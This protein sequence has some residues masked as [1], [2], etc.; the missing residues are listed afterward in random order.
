MSPVR[1][2]PRAERTRARRRTAEPAAEAPLKTI[3]DP[4]CLVFAVPDLADGTLSSHDRDML[5]AARLLA[6]AQSGAVVVVAI[7]GEDDFAAAGADRLIEVRGDAFTGYCP[8]AR[9]T[10]VIAAMARFSPRHVLFPDTPTDGGHVGRLVAA[11]LGERAAGNVQRIDGSDI[12]RR[13]GDGSLDYVRAAPRFLLV[14]PEAAAPVSGA[15]F[16]ARVIAETSAEGDQ[17]LHDGGLQPIDPHGVPLAEADFIVAGGSGVS[18]W[19]AFHRVAAALGATEGA[20]RVACD[21]GA[22]A[23]DRQVGASGTLVDPRCYLAFGI[24]GA[25]QHLQG[26]QRCPRVVGGNTDRHAAMVKRADLAVIADAQDVMV[27]LADL[28]EGKPH[29]D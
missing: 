7:A 1:R 8:E 6:D 23:R 10:V 19:D 17:R 3:G 29:G 11:R 4:A 25:A 21:G 20:S 14:A 27:A 12:E 22:M 5:G 13:G 28:M 18:D 26:I 9:A 16:E 2:D 24:S 15:R